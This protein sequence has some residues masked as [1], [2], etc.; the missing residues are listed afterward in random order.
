MSKLIETPE[1]L[2]LAKQ[3]ESMDE[4]H[5]SIIESDVAKLPKLIE[6]RRAK[7]I[8]DR[9]QAALAAAE[10]AA[11]AHGFKVSD[12]LEPLKGKKVKSITPKYAHP[13]DP[14]LTW[15]GMGRRPKWIVELED[16]GQS[17]EEFLI[18]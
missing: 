17:R 5:L 11:N 12:L 1:L 3:I 8:E 10:E 4:D 9:R 15:A 18:K 14:S 13:S 2:E 6:L 7:V 16:A